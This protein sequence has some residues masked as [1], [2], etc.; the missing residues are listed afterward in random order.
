MIGLTSGQLK[1][2]DEKWIKR[3]TATE[4]ASK[5]TTCSLPIAVVNVKGLFSP[6]TGN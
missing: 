3:Y 4:N 1:A 5:E 2:V 6:R